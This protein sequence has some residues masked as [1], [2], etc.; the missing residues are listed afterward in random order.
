[1]QGAQENNNMNEQLDAQM[2][3]LA[4]VIVI[5][6]VGLGVLVHALWFM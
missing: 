1:V 4:A 6:I 5:A 3:F 2:A